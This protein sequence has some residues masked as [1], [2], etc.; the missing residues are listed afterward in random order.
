M[1]VA[2][3][4]Q[5]AGLEIEEEIGRGGM[6]I[7]YRAFDPALD[8]FVALKAI[9]AE[10]SADVLFKLRFDRE[11]KVQASLDHTNIVHV[12]SSG[13][14]E[15]DLFIALKLI[16]GPSLATLLKDG[17]LHPREALRILTP[18]AAALDYAH[19][20]GP[21]HRDLKP[22][23]I[24]LDS[25]G[26]PFL[27]D[28]GLAWIPGD[29]RMTTTGAF[30]GTT[31]Y[32]SP[33]QLR[34]QSVGPASDVYSLTCVLYEC[35]SGA[36]PF[37]REPVDPATAAAGPPPLSAIRRGLPKRI[38]EVVGRGMAAAPPSRYGSAGELLETASAALSRHRGAT[39]GRTARL[40]ARNAPIRSLLVAL[41]LL[42]TLGGG[43]LGH[44][45][46]AGDAQ[47]S[48]TRPVESPSL[49]LTSP[50][51]WRPAHPGRIAGLHL[52]DPVGLRGP[53]GTILTAGMTAASGRLLLP[54]AFL[55]TLPAQP[56]QTQ[57]VKL[58]AGDA[59]RYPRLA[60]SP[61][62]PADLYVLPTSAGVA[63]VACRGASAGGRR[64]CSQI[65]ATLEVRRG[66]TY[67][68][69]A[70]VAYGKALNRVLATLQRR[71]GRGYDKLADARTANAQEAAARSLFEA[72]DETSWRLAEV[73][74]TPQSAEGNE[75]VIEALRR[76][77]AA[78]DML[79]EAARWTSTAAYDEARDLIRRREKAVRASVR[80]LRRLG[81]TVR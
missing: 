12:F 11:R 62:G 2:E 40:P 10:L 42:A 67:P 74:V 76:A 45:L 28:F 32:A 1:T 58:R 3:G 31:A 70:S 18:I 72:F 38:D 79:A 47:P 35:L 80:R 81:Y 46:G 48:F 34:G 19:E 22:Q 15:G 68:L 14:S 5:F 57:A 77:A 24:L 27:T 41:V 56:R 6:G 7:V 8:R 78:Y 30:M 29:A 16:D 61:I 21:V 64:L 39:I 51:N 17:P 36:I 43:F 20:Q 54:R 55:R 53:D 26:R 50:H 49:S 4:R 63:T 13:E 25:T 59:Y 60:T 71:R 69:G 9:H 23:N 44:L 73:P 65:A 75:A 37:P 33:E 66:G 52:E